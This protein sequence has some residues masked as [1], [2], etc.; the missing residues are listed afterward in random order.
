MN[1]LKGS[2]PDERG[3]RV[4]RGCATRVEHTYTI[5]CAIVSCHED[6]T[7]VRLAPMAGVRSDAA[8]TDRIRAC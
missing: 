5:T 8:I 4:M 3:V 1:K 6:V 2:A 7:V